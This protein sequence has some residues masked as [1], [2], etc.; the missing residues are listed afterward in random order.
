MVDI[1][2]Q[3]LP[4]GMVRCWDRKGMYEI[5]ADPSG[6]KPKMRNYLWKKEESLAEKRKA[7]SLGDAIR[8]NT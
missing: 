1:T 4:N 2:N 7:Y 6:I 5:P 3:A 8:F